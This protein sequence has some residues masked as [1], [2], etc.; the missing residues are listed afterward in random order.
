M[1]VEIIVAVFLGILAGIFT[2]LIPGI[3]INLVFGIVLGSLAFLFEISTFAAVAFIVSIAIMHTFID[4]IP[5]I[6]LGAPN[7]DTALSTMPGH[8]FLMKGHGH[9][10]LQYTLLGSIIAVVLLFFIVPLFMIVIPFAYSFISDMMAFILI[11]VSIFL[12]LPEK[13]KWAVILV[14]FLSGFL[15]IASM[16]LGLD[17]SL[18]PLLTGLFGSSTIITSIKSSVQVPK[19]EIDKISVSFK[20]IAPPTFATALV[21]PICS[22][23]PGIGASQAAVIGSR[24]IKEKS[25]KQFL[26][27]LGSINTLVMAVSFVTLFLVGKSRTGAAAAVFEVVR[28]D[29]KI[30]FLIGIIV[31]ITS[32]I[33]VPVTLY[34]SKIFALNISKINYSLISYGVLV[35][36]CGVVLSFSGILGFLVFVVATFV[37]LFCSYIGVRK[38]F[39]M[40]ALLI[41]TILFYFPV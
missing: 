4:F 9:E 38:G 22:F 36:L 24:V 7:E 27:L 3:H 5:S 41:P 30:L 33:A 21:S 23:F 20:E 8:K 37:G 2:G 18:M 13:S 25:R 28:V 32:A 40:G 6:Y 12:I 15:G 34:F 1:L 14:F 19:Q 16:G 39:L 17:Q 26:I 11:W 35:L 29:I 31:I 10:A